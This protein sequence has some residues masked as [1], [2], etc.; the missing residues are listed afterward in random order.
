[1]RALWRMLLTLAWRNLWRNRRRT[2]VMLFAL[3]LGVWAMV[4]MGAFMRGMSGQI[5]ENTFDNLT[6]HLQIHQPGYLDDPVIDYRLR[7]DELLP[8]LNELPQAKAALR[9]RVPGVIRSEREATGVT[10]V[11]IDPVQEQGVSFIANAVSEGR[12]LR[13]GADSGLL[14]GR[15]LA[16]RLETGVGKRVVVMSEAVNNEIADRGMRVVGLFDAPLQ[17]TE[18]ALLF[19]GRESLQQLLDIPGAVSEVALR[20]PDPA[21]VDAVV[22]RLRA[23]YPAYDI[24]PWHE[25]EPVARI[26][27]QMYDGFA[28]IWHLIVFL[29]MGFGIINTLLM[30]VFERTREFG[31][32]QALGLRPG[33]ILLQVW[34]E[35]LL[36]L[37]LGLAIGN[38][39]SWATVWATGE[40]IDVSAFAR[41]MEMAQLSNVIPFLIRMDDLLLANAVVIILGLLAS[42]YPAWRAARLVPAEAITRI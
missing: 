26:I 37:L 28:L 19:V 8:L 7:Q 2:L 16:Q 12:Q 4:V 29:A 21:Q 36:L 25:I 40:G 30:A 17:A 42:L 39:A 9:V 1:M 31:L 13:S 20:L 32:Y 3:V 33:F 23:R 11:G 24:Q 18:T 5:L 6:A 10:L 14:L 34:L 38:L 41:G 27:V 22:E 15:A 35:A